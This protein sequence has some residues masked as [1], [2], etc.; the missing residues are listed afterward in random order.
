MITSTKSATNVSSIWQMN[1]TQTIL[2]F[3]RARTCHSKCSN[4]SQF[5]LY[6]EYGCKQLMPTKQLSIFFTLS[7]VLEHHCEN[8]RSN[9]WEVFLQ[10]AFFESRQILEKNLWKSSCFSKIASSKS[11]T[12]LILKSYMNILSGNF[13]KFWLWKYL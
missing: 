2:K 13:L 9:D 11:R 6:F 8:T 1:F 4:D 10:S 5:L 7:Y 12:S 3:S